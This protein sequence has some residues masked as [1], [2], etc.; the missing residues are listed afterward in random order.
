VAQKL[1]A[2]GQLAIGGDGKGAQ[3][4]M[5]AIKFMVRRF[6]LTSSGQCPLRQRIQAP[7]AVDLAGLGWMCCFQAEMAI[8]PP[9]AA[10]TAPEA[11]DTAL[12][13][14]LLP[15]DLRLT[16]EQFALVCEANPDAV[17]N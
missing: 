14:L 10:P 8:A 12:V 15:Q 4:A 13:P 9:V 7:I 17:W 11:A 2:Q 3:R 1:L 5:T 6:C 16:P